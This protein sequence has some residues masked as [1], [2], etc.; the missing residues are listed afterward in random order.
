[1]RTIIVKDKKRE[2]EIYMEAHSAIE[3][4]K[5]LKDNPYPQ[6][7]D[8]NLQWDANYRF[9]CSF[10]SDI[11]LDSKGINRSKVVDE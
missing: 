3:Y 11:Y 4:G 10:Y 9:L 7:T 1:M 5:H 2:S 6:N 8:E